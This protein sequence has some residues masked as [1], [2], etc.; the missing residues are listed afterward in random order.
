M[1]LRGLFVGIGL[2]VCAT[3]FLSG[4]GCSGGSTAG[5]RIT[6][7]AAAV[8]TPSTLSS[9]SISAEGMAAA[10]PQHLVATDVP[11]AF[12]ATQFSISSW[13]GRERIG[14]VLLRPFE[15]AENAQK[16]H[17]M[18]SNGFAATETQQI[19][20]NSDGT[21]DVGTNFEHLLTYVCDVGHGGVSGAA[22]EGWGSIAP[23]PT[24]CSSP[25]RSATTVRL[26]GSIQGQQ[27]DGRP[28]L[29]QAV[30]SEADTP[31]SLLY[32]FE[33]SQAGFTLTAELKLI[34]IAS[35]DA[36]PESMQLPSGLVETQLILTGGDNS[37]STTAA[38]GTWAI[39]SVSFLDG[40][41][42]TGN[43][44]VVFGASPDSLLATGQVSLPLLDQPSQ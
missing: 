10:D 15:C 4:V 1:G 21:L 40:G 14:S 29:C 36:L 30:L 42:T 27:F 19:F 37:Y 38:T 11:A 28:D 6:F 18:L 20:V 39:D 22:I 2:L 3:V 34:Q 32:V 41:R 26:S 23:A 43:L 17:Q 9:Y 8:G 13:Q 7:V 5:D 35:T 25:D 12:G 16:L 44:S 33:M 24:L 31:T